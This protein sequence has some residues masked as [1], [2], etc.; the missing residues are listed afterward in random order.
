[1]LDELEITRLEYM[2]ILKNRGKNVSPT[3][4]YDTL[5]KKV[6][7][8]KLRDLICLSSIRGVISND[9]SLEIILD[10]L[11][12]DFHKKKL[13]NLKDELYRNIQRIKER[14]IKS[15]MN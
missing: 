7:Y 6:K 10:A 3:I 14:I 9:L 1:M 4:S 13:K 2:D 8:I 12:K 11:F 15:Q 5:L